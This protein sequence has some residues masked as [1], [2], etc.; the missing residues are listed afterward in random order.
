MLRINTSVLLML[1]A[2]AASTFVGCGHPL[3][4]GTKGSGAFP[5]DESDAQPCTNECVTL[6]WDP[7]TEPDLAGYKI[8]YGASSG[9]YTANVDVGNVTTYT[10][11]GLTPGVTYY[12]V[13][14]AHDNFGNESGYSNEVNKAL[15]LTASRYRRS[16]LTGIVIPGRLPRCELVTEFEFSLKP[17]SCGSPPVI[18][19]VSR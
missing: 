13:A 16:I 2:I 3:L 1:S 4:H 8:Y 12:F 6:A 11:T 15:S 14:T 10:V 17:I 19:S 5:I 7:N 18:T 9:T